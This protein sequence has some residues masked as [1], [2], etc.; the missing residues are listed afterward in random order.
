M[1]RLILQPTRDDWPKLRFGLNVCTITAL[2]AAGLMF[3]SCAR[4]LTGTY[5]ADDG[6]IYYLQQSGGTLW[7]AGLSLD[8]ELPADFVWHRGLYFTNVFRGTIN[9]DNTIVGEWSDVSRG[10]TLNSGTLTVKIDSSGGVT[11]LTKLTATGGF[12]ATTWTRT[13]PLDDTKFNGTTLDI[14]S[15]FDA[16]HKN[17]G[18]TIHHNLKPYRDATV[19]YGRVVISHVDYIADNH[20]V[21]SEIPHVNYDP[22]FDPPIPNFPNF[23][24]ID[25][26][27]DEFFVAN[28]S[29]ADFDMRLK[30]D[31]DRL[32]PEFYTTGWG[33]RTFGPEVFRLKLNDATTHQKLN[34]TGSEAYM[35]VETI[36]FGRNL[37]QDIQLPGWSEMDGNSALI[38]GRPING[39][40]LSQN[41]APDCDFVQPCPNLAGE[42]PQQLQSN[43]LDAPA[44]V[45]FGNLIL[46]ASGNGVLDRFGIAGTGIGTYVRVTGAL[47]LDCG[48]LPE[49]GYPCFDGND[50]NPDD[51]SS[52][53]STHQ[54]QEIHP[55]YSIDV[56]NSPFR[57]EDI[58]LPARKNL[59]GAWGGSDGSTY[60][61][62]QIGNTIWWLG[63]MRD[64]QPMQRGTNFPIIG[65]LQLKSAFDAG[66]PPCPSQQC[67]AF[68]TV[69]K[70]T[71]TES[72]I[73]TVIEGDWAGV[74]QSTS[75]GSSGGHMKFF[76]FNHKIIVAATPSIFPVTIEKMYEPED[77]TP[78][79]IT[80]TQPAVIQYPH[81]A[82]LT[83]NYSLADGTG[84]GVQSFTPMMDNAIIVGN[85]SLQS[86]Q[87]IKLL[88]EMNL[89]QHTFTVSAVDNAGNEDSSSVTFTIIVT[90]DSIKDDVNQFVAT[91]SIR[92]HGLANSLLSKLDA[93]A[94]ARA[95]GDCASAN[96]DYETFIKKLQTQIGN[97]VDG[98]AAAIMIADAQHLIAPCP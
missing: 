90:P 97:G 47:V 63:Q 95:A 28:A 32:E 39:P 54:N 78:P 73:E 81:N 74:P 21:E 77:T 85:H 71:I 2:V 14:I 69:F 41:P 75:A 17:N 96:T 19:F 62:R 13:D 7:W 31:L 12:G 45:A 92:S 46:S 94:N 76:V 91:G 82:T 5:I 25:R 10:L 37:A 89:D 23:G 52:D 83:L 34:Y 70:G 72:P 27:Y 8:R 93:G 48:H 88:T 30:V 51:E 1:K 18:E 36:M 49:H 4:N 16:V 65:A 86:G 24:I 33:G 42:T 40:T 98:P 56:I 35:G 67:W 6:G 58:A 38:N 68:A 29:D 84:S 66:D 20:G 44:G 26:T 50:G 53:V 64:R 43:Y 11:K 22:P 15:R 55:V 57:P 87:A 61:V 79:V 3:S 60:Y 59:T 9:S 80:I